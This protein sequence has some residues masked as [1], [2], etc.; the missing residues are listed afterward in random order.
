M[1]RAGTEFGSHTVTH[2]QLVSLAEKQVEYEVKVSKETIEQELGCT[3]AS[4]SYPYAFPETNAAFVRMLRRNLQQ[5]GYSHGVTTIIGTAGPSD[6]AL[7]L[8]RLPVNSCDDRAL[9]EAKLEGGY[10]W[11][12]TAQAAFKTMTAAKRRPRGGAGLAAGIAGELNK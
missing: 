6:D 11:L 4:F 2:P 3:V 9:L 5:A 7:L 8:P 1:H 10:N 12:H